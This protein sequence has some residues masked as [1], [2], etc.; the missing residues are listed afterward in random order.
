MA[1]LFSVGNFSTFAQVIA[2][3]DYD[4]LYSGEAI[5]SQRHSPGVG[6]N[7]KKGRIY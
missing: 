5:G 3:G 6:G 2:G 1:I 4:S 7:N